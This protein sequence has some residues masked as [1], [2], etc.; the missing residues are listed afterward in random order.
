MLGGM[1]VD[2]MGENPGISVKQLPYTVCWLSMIK[3]A[4]VGAPFGNI[5][6]SSI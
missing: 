2:W 5:H 1:G 6:D 3:G 4:N